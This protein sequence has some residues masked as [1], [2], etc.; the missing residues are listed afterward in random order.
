MR[1][2]YEVV[3]QALSKA[4]LMFIL[5]SILLTFTNIESSSISGGFHTN[6]KKGEYIRAASRDPSCS[7]GLRMQI[8]SAHRANFQFAKS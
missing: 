3:A 8:D 4:L 7:T 5:L 2:E 1:S 6:A